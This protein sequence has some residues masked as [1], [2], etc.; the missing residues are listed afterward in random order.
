MNK[1]PRKMRT[2][3]ISIYGDERDIYPGRV[4]YVAVRT[5]SNLYRI[6]HVAG[7]LLR[8]SSPVKR[9]LNFKEAIEHLAEAQRS[10]S[11]VGEPTR[12]SLSNLTTKHFSH[13][14]P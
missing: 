11:M 8:S 7:G 3:V 4:S 6:D 13:Y 2:H 9:E 10:I 12:F 5:K 14:Q 1:L